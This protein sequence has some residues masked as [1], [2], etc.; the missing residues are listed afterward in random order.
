MGYFTAI[1]EWLMLHV[2]IRSFKTE[3]YI[4]PRESPRA[5]CGLWVITCQC[6]AIGG[7]K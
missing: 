7:N 1:T 5:N 6:R 3:E 2:I 4:T